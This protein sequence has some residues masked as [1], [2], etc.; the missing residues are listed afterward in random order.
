MFRKPFQ[1]LRLDDKAKIQP[2]EVI[3]S[4]VIGPM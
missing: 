4:N 1:T 2:L 3:H